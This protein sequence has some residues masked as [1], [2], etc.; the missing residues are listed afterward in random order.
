[1]KRLRTLLTDGNPNKM[2]DDCIKGKSEN[3]FSSKSR[4]N[5]TVTRFISSGSH[6][7]FLFNIINRFF[8]AITNSYRTDSFLETKHNHCNQ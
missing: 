2:H 8:Y 3:T 5:I 7:H 4:G 1:M 6:A